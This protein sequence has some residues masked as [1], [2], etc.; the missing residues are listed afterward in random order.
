M[1][2]SLKELHVIQALRFFVMLVKV[3]V[4]EYWVFG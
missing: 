4:F 3:F 1:P 2:V